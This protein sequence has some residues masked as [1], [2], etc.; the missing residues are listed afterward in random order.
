MKNLPPLA[1]LASFRAA[2]R[3]ESFTRAALD[4]HVT[5]GAVS[6]AVRQ[7]EEHFGFPLFERRNRGVFLTERGKMFADRID[8]LFSGL[9]AACDELRNA[10][11]GQR[12]SVSCEPTLAMRWLMPRLEEFRRIAPDVDILL[13]TAGGPI[14]LASRG[15]DLAIRRSDFSLPGTGHVVVLGREAVGPVCSPAYW[16]G[17]AHGPKRVLHTRTRPR[18]WAEWAQRSGQTVEIGSIG[19]ERFFDHF[20]F[21]LQAAVAG[22]GMAIGPYPLVCDDLENGLLVAPCGF[23]DTPFEY[24]ALC[25]EEPAPGGRVQRF[26]DWL[27]ASLGL[28]RD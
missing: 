24:V 27:E 8:A 28:P 20:Y 15:V 16:Q 13:S 12:L 10:P 6:R 14:D 18:A 25:R 4:L 23:V 26:L 7:L 11:A 5:H 2:A 1:P 22:L 19:S 3:H 17:N 9:E 21:I